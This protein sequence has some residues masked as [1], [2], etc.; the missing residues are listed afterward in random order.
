MVQYKHTEDKQARRNERPLSG[1]VRGE[2]ILRKKEGEERAL[3][4]RKRT[5]QRERERQEIAD[6]IT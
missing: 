4:D 5:R 6:R 3:M 1:F 2:R